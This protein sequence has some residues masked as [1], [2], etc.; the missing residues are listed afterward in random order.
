MIDNLPL[1][2]AHH[3]QF[4]LRQTGTIVTDLADISQSLHI[5]ATTPKGA[6]PLRPHFG[7]DMWRYI[8]LPPAIA[9]PHLVR[10]LTDAWRDW[11]P[12][13]TVQRI[14]PIIDGATITARLFFAL[15]D[16]VAQ[17][18]TVQLRDGV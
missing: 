12:R 14:K 8:D 17:S 10:E 13:I 9:A 11:E 5:I 2:A 18:L 15:T 3:W 6:D 1:P 16:G 4:A 7:C